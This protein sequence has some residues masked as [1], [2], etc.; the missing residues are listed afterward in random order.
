VLRGK[1]R[2]L[3]DQHDHQNGRGQRHGN[4]GG[5]FLHLTSGVGTRSLSSSSY[6]GL[7][8]FTPCRT[9]LIRDGSGLVLIPAI[10]R[11]E[12]THDKFHE[13]RGALLDSPVQYGTIWCEGRKLPV[14]VARWD[15]SLNG[16]RSLRFWP[17][18]THVGRLVARLFFQVM[19]SAA[20][21]CNPH[22]YVR[23]V[24]LTQRL[25]GTRV[26]IVRWS[27]PGTVQVGHSVAAETREPR[28][29]R[30]ADCECKYC[31]MQPTRCASIDPMVRAQQL[32]RLGLLN[33][34]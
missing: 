11:R 4:A 15:G 20:Q 13:D 27:V 6:T 28:P 33:A 32:S 18:K 16:R 26:T 21:Y 10:E 25:P 31:P 23:R 2:L 5:E 14:V 24:Q 1:V 8:T 7:G 3:H 17:C 12:S 29:L 22:P 9:V 19:T 30:P 34:R